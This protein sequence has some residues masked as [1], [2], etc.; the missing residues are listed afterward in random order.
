MKENV[1]DL[2]EF[3]KKRAKENNEALNAEVV[4]V[5]E[6][7]TY[8]GLSKFDLEMHIVDLLLEDS[9][10]QKYLTLECKRELAV[11]KISFEGFDDDEKIYLES[12]IQSAIAAKLMMNTM[13][14]LF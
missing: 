4:A 3:V 1:Y 5:G 10:V 8:V 9:L 14:H 13:A 7:S 2:A 11:Q 12:V 6:V